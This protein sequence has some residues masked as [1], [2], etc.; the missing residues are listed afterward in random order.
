LDKDTEE[1]QRHPYTF[2]G[3]NNAFDIVMR[4]VAGAADMPLTRLF[5]VSPAGMNATG[6]SDDRHFYDHVASRRE[7]HM[8]PALEQL[9]QFLI[10]S[11]LGHMPDGYESTWLPLWQPTDAEAAATEATRATTA[12]T[13]WNMGVVDEGNIAEDIYSRE[14]YKGFSQANVKNAQQ[15]AR[16]SAEAQQQGFEAQASGGITLSGKPGEGRLGK[17]AL[18]NQVVAPPEGEGV[19]EEDAPK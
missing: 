3:V 16:Q 9:D 5:G 8:D 14:V 11:A 17:K 6:E 2:S 4:D 15:V 1:Y 7:A 19:D 10:R 13:Y 18:Q 12:Q